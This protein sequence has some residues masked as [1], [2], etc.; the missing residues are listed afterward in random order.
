MNRLYNILWKR[1]QLSEYCFD[2]LF[3]NTEDFREWFFSQSFYSVETFSEMEIYNYG[4]AGKAGEGSLP[5][6]CP[7]LQ[8][9]AVPLAGPH[10]WLW[11]RATPLSVPPKPASNLSH[12]HTAA[13]M[14]TMVCIPSP[15]FPWC[16]HVRLHLLLL[17]CKKC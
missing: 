3:K 12:S 13:A 15:D 6:I 4:L 1:K 10:S 2:L 7:F 16:L 9:L 11:L 8:S 14:Q 17:H 5:S